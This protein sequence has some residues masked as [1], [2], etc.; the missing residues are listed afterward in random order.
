MAKSQTLTKLQHLYKVTAKDSMRFSLSSV[1]LGLVI[2]SS[3]VVFAGCSQNRPVP[4]ADAPVASPTPITQVYG[5]DVSTL[6]I[7]SDIHVPDT[8]TDVTLKLGTAVQDFHQGID[9]GDIMWG[10]IFVAKQVTDGYDVLGYVNVNHGGSGTQQYLVVYH[11]TETAKTNTSTIFI[12]DRIPIQ[13][14]E[15]QAGTTPDDYTVVVSSLTRKP[16]EPMVNAPTIP[17]TS[18]FKVNQHHIDGGENY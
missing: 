16:D 6:L 15:I 14:I 10:D 12:G 13:K 3:A 11:V 18:T 9:R 2:M 7:G 8:E 17:Q 5:S 1:V 4:A